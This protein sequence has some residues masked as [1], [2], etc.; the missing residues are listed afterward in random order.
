[1]RGSK[2]RREGQAMEYPQN[3]FTDERTEG[4]HDSRRQARSAPTR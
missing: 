1:M 4:L 3:F 2:K